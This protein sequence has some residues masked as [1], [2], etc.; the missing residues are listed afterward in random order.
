MLYS[1]LLERTLLLT[2]TRFVDSKRKDVP[3]PGCDVEK[4]WSPEFHNKP[5]H[6]RKK[7]ERERERERERD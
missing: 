3:A 2:K 5:A 1:L 6:E 7:R 4:P